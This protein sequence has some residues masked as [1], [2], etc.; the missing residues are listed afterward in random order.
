MCAL[1]SGL[2][3]EKAS[4]WLF[5]VHDS[6]FPWVLLVAVVLAWMCRIRV[7]DDRDDE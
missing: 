1:L 2:T 3:S 4:L 6:R 5:N 7:K